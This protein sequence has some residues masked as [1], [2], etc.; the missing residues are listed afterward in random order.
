MMGKKVFFFFG[1]V[2]YEVRER[3]SGIENRAF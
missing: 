3:E 2:V 1:I